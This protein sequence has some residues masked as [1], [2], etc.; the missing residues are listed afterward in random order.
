MVS[1]LSLSLLL[2]KMD[3]VIQTLFSSTWNSW[4]NRYRLVIFFLWCQTVFSSGRMNTGIIPWYR[5]KKNATGCHC[6]KLTG[7]AKKDSGSLCSGCRRNVSHWKVWMGSRDRRGGCHQ[8]CQRS[9]SCNSF[10]FGSWA[11]GSWPVLSHLILCPW[12][13]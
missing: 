3:I 7:S 6:W 8:S 10:A 2:Y 11:A 12:R 13:F 1:S 4:E 9:P 5:G